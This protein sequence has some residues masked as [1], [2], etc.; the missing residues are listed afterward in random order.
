MS[1]CVGAGL[2]THSL[3]EQQVFFPFEPSPQ[4]LWTLPFWPPCPELFILALPPPCSTWVEELRGQGPQLL[5]SETVSQT[6]SSLPPHVLLLGICDG[7]STLHSV[8]GSLLS[9][10]ILG[11]WGVIFLYGSKM[12]I[13]IIGIESTASLGTPSPPQPAC[14]SFQNSHPHWTNLEIPAVSSFQLLLLCC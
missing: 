2:L 6:K 10:L 8:S 5:T 12:I 3:Q 7:D 1:C 13:F 4:P 11:L 9:F 14:C